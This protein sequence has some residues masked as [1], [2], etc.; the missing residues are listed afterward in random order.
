MARTARGEEAAALAETT[1]AQCPT[2]TP[3]ATVTC[4]AT[5]L[6][7]TAALTSGVNVSAWSRLSLVSKSAQVCLCVH[8]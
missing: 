4:S 8:R 7:L 5:A 2:W 6:S 3:S 1:C